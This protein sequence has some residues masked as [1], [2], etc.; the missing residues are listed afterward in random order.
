MVLMLALPVAVLAQTEKKY[1]RPAIIALEDLKEY[2]DLSPER[3]KLLKTALETAK[4]T[5][6]TV[7][8]YGGS[9][10][11]Q[12]G[13]DCSGAMYYVL[14][15]EG[16]KVP[17]SSAQQFLWIR[18]AG[19]MVEVPPKVK[20]LGNDLFKKLQPGDLVFWSGTYIPTDARTVKVSHVGM[21]LGTEKKDGRPVMIN[22]T[23]GRSYRGKAGDGFGVYDFR[24]PSAKSR[25]KFVGFGSPPG[26]K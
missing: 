7:Y 22:A 23:K 9:S 25:S 10:P 6:A 3:K 4:K 18:D 21:Y 11:E 24:I 14:Q 15:K 26:L 1:H 2:P 17:R 12:G 5:R 13:F 8:K 20:S 16:L 19:N